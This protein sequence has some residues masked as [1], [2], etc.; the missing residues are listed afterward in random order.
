M[1]NALVEFRMVN[2]RIV[3]VHPDEVCALE[4]GEPTPGGKSVVKVHMNSGYFFPVFG[5]VEEASAK[6]FGE[7][8]Q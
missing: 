6:L 8:E 2:T 5:T 3:R 7:D 1:R 4:M